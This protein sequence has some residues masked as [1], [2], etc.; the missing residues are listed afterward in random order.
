[1]SKFDQAISYT[2]MALICFAS[3][4][5]SD[6]LFLITGW[7]ACAAALAKLFSLSDKKEI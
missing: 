1:M 6:R 4:N 2:L 3:Y 5:H 7:I